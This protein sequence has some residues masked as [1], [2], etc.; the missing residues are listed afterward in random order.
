[1]NNSIS[2][3]QGNFDNI[4]ELELQGYDY[5]KVREQIGGSPISPSKS[6]LV[7]IVVAGLISTIFVIGYHFVINEGDW[8][9][10]FSDDENA[11]GSNNSR[12]QSNN[13]GGA[14]WGQ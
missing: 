4:I 6:I 12:R 9:K 13:Y 11:G 7:Y 10:V 5:E 8:G 3:L 1:M 14:A 2:E